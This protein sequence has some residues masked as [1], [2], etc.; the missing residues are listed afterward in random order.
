MI[1]TPLQGG[2]VGGGSRRPT[3][4]TDR[5]AGRQTEQ[6]QTDGRNSRSACAPRFPLRKIRGMDIYRCVPTLHTVHIYHP[7]ILSFFFF[8]P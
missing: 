3:D 2:S 5:Q 4:R 8:H 1:G 6:R 7:L